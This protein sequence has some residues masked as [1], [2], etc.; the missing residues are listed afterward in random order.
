[1]NNPKVASKNSDSLL[2]HFYQTMVRIRNFEQAAR[3]LYMEG[4]LPGFMHMSVGQEATPTGVCSALREDDYI[5]TT[6]RGHGDAI[7]KGVSI[8]AAMA[9]LF[10]KSTGICK[11]KGGSMHIADVS[12]GILGANG[13]VGAG[14]PIAVGAAFSARYRKTDQVAV[15]FFGDG[16][17]AGGPLHESMNMA[18]LWK[19]PLIFVRQNNQYAES[20]SQV[21]FQGIPDIVKWAEGYGMSAERVDGNNVMAVYQVAQKAVM[22]AR[23]GKGPSFIESLTYRWYGHNMGDPGTWRPQAEIEAWKAKDP[24]EQF[25]RYLLENQLLAESKLEE[26]KAKEEEMTA[27]AIRKAELAEP[28]ALSSVFEGVY[29]D[30]KLGQLAIRGDRK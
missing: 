20:T 14:I 15:S 18:V 23:K 2:T 25:R 6:H 13:I 12:K 17:S 1:M 9:E 3:R 19:L 10:A 4:R 24:I 5:T 28:P 8:D 11:G 21:D 27:E 29:V 30:A 26:I 7:A 22:R 16:A